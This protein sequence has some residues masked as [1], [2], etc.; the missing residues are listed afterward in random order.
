MTADAILVEIERVGARAELVAGKLSVRPAR[1]VPAELRDA[2]RAAIPPLFAL[3]RK[4]ERD[5]PCSNAA[6]ELRRF[7]DWRSTEVVRF[8][9][10]IDH[11]H[12]DGVPTYDSREIDLVLAWC[13][14][15]GI[16]QLPVPLRNALLDAKTIFGGRIDPSTVPDLADTLDEP[17]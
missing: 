15:E 4:R 7:T 12:E 10:D 13:A 9:C 11:E 1:L 2:I 3:L 8:C 5:R 16:R 17:Q 14:R 6:C